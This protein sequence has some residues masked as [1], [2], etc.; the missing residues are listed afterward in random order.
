MAGGGEHAAEP[1]RD[2]GPAPPRNRAVNRARAGTAGIDSV[3]DPRGHAVSWQ[4][5][6]RLCQTRR[7]GAAP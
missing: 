7:S 6:R 4:R 5:Q 1:V 2:R 3:N